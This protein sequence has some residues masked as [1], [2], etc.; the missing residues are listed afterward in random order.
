MFVFIHLPIPFCLFLRAQNLLDDPIYGCD[1]DLSCIPNII[2]HFH[3]TLCISFCS[4]RL[5]CWLIVLFHH[6]LLVVDRPFFSSVILVCMRF[7]SLRFR[8]TFRF[9]GHSSSS[10]LFN[11]ISS[12][13]SRFFFSLFS[14]FFACKQRTNCLV[15]V[16]QIRKS[17]REKQTKTTNEKMPTDRLLCAHTLERGRLPSQS[18]FKKITYISLERLSTVWIFSLVVLCWASTV[19]SHTATAYISHALFYVWNKEPVIQYVFLENYT[20]I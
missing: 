20:K 17:E 15:N 5:L 4:F 13:C 12:V 14:T 19:H 10:S 7:F 1:I 8:S 3:I 9:Y 11:S 16:N 6:L 18:K 2:Q